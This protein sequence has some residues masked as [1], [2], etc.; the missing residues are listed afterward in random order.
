[1]KG[2]RFTLTSSRR[3][4]NVNQ[5]GRGPTGMCADGKTSMPKGTSEAARSTNRPTWGKDVE[6]RRQ[7]RQREQPK[8]GERK[9]VE[10]SKACRTLV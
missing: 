8:N 10:R 2:S 1:M 6:K 3:G 4:G 5:A 7:V 9:G